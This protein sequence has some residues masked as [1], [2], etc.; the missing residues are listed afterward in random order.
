MS[1]ARLC[2]AVWDQ[3]QRVDE[4]GVCEFRTR[5]KGC[6]TEH[7]TLNI[8]CNVNVTEC[9]QRPVSNDPKHPT[10]GFTFDD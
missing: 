10:F 9:R 3:P 1:G 4:A 6:A 5:A 8:Q 7:S 2:P